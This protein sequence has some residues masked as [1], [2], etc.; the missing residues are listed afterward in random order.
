MTTLHHYQKSHEC[1]FVC[2]LRVRIHSTTIQ[3]S[4][5]P[6]FPKS[7]RSASHF[8][9]FDATKRMTSHDKTS[10]VDFATTDSNKSY[11]IHSPVLN[12]PDLVKSDTKQEVIV[13]F[14]VHYFSL[15]VVM[16]FYSIIGAEQNRVKYSTVGKIR[17]KR[18]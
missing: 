17:Q 4:A 12:L 3:L 13:L 10:D 18:L 9:H 1:K 7:Q 8:G 14:I 11:R 2:L 15:L 16:Y 5:F 6:T